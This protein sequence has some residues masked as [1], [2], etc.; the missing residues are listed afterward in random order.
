MAGRTRTN[1]AGYPCEEMMAPGTLRHRFL[2]VVAFFGLLCALSA[3]SVLADEE[4]Q[5]LGSSP[6]PQEI[7]AALEGEGPAPEVIEQTNPKAAEQLPHN[8]L[9]RGE[10]AELLSAVFAPELEATAGIFDELEVARFQGDHLA[11]L[12][13]DDQ[14]GPG[15]DP[16]GENR[17]TLL[18]STLPLRTESDSGESL[19]VDLALE[20]DEEG[21][22]QPTNPLI[23]VGIPGQLGDGISLPEAGVEVSLLGAPDERAPSI[24]EES[25]AFYPN[26]AR[27]S[28]LTVA[29]TPLGVETSTQLRSPD[30]PQGQ[31]FNLTLPADATLREVDG[32]G[33]EV[34]GQN[35]KPL[36]VVPAPT[37]IDAA[38]EAV[39]VDLET[40]GDSVLITA[41]PDQETAF[42]ILVDP[43]WQ[44]YTY[45][46][47][48]GPMPDYAGWG[49]ETNNV[50]LFQTAQ[51]DWCAACN[52]YIW[53]LELN[54]FPGSAAPWSRALWRYRVPR[55]ADDALIGK[56]PTSYINYAMFGRLG[57]DVG[58]NENNHS[59]AHDP[60][61]EYYLWDDNNGFV[62][63]GKRLGTEGNLSDP[64]WQ[65]ILQ[66]PNGNENAKQ[67]GIELVTTQPYSQWR[68][69]YV[70]DAWFELT[71]NDYPEFTES[72]SPAAW[73][74]NSPKDKISFKAVDTGLGIYEMRVREP[75]STGLVQNVGTQQ[76]CT[77]GAGN[78]CPRSWSSTA[79]GPV[80]NY[81][82][83]ILPQGENWVTLDASDAG[84][85]LASQQGTKLPEVRIKVD[86]TPPALA[87]SGNLTEQ[88]TVGTKLSNYVLKYRVTDG[89]HASAEALAPFGTQGIG[90][91]QMQRPLGSATDRA[92][93]IWMVDRE[94]NRVQEFDEEGK[95]L[96]QF[97]SKGSGNGQFLEP[98]NI[99]RTAAGKLWVTDTGNHRVQQ[100]TSSGQYIQQFGTNG[101]AGGT[102]FVSPFGIAATSDGKLWISD[103][104][105]GRVAQFRETVSQASERH[106]RNAEG[107][108]SS[109]HGNTEF[110]A[111]AGLA[112]DSQNNLWVVD[113]GN[114]RLQRF[115]SSGAYVSAFGAQ[116]AG[117]G[118]LKSPYNVAISSSG[119]L[120]VTDAGNNR[121]EEFQPSGAFVR[122]FGAQGAGPNQFTE[123][124]ALAFGAGNTIFV[125]DAGNRRIARWQ[126]AE[127][128][129][130]S[131]AAGIQIKVDGEVAKEE[132]PGC[133]TKDCELV[134]EWNL[135]SSQYSD[136]PHIVK[137]IATDGVG[138]TTTKELSIVLYPDRT[139]PSIALSGS[140]TEQ[141][142]LGTTRPRYI[143]NL[144]ASD[145]G[146]A[147][148]SNFSS[149]FGSSGSGA[150]QFAHPADA[151]IDVSGNIWIADRGNHRIQ[152]FSPSGEFLS[153]FGTWGA[154]NG[155]LKSPSSLAIDADGHIWVADKDNNRVQEF[156]PGGEYLSKFGVSGSA[157]G[158]L[159]SPEGIAIAPNGD[160]W[161]SC[162]VLT[163]KR[164]QRF[165]DKGE[166]VK[167]VGSYGSGS[168]QLSQPKGIDFDSYGN[169][170]VAD[171][172]NNRISVFNKAGEFVKQLG[173]QGSGEGQ[174]NFPVEVEVDAGDNVWIGDR[175]NNRVQLLN[176]SGEY[177]AQFGSSGSGPGQFSFNTPLGIASDGMGRI[178]V[179]D[180]NNARA[181]KW[182]T[183]PGT[184]SGVASTLVKV[185][186]SVVDSSSLGCPT[187]ACSVSREWILDA[188]S[189]AAGQHTAE[190]TTT[191]VA[192]LSTTKSLTFNIGKDTTAPQ[193][194]SNASL[195]TAPEGWV[196]QQTY[197]YTASAAD[198]GGYGNTSLMLKIDGKAVK[199][200]TQS[201]P[202]GAC[203]QAL[204]GSIDMAAYEGG[205]HPAELI[206]TDGAGN[207]STKKWNINVDPEGHISTEEATATLEAVQETS[208]VNAVGESEEEEGYEGTAPQLGLEEVNEGLEA[209]GTQV[210]T[211]ITTDPRNGVTMKIL[212]NAALS[213]PCGENEESEVPCDMYQEPESSSG[214]VPIT[215]AP[216]T[217]A[218]SASN[219]QLIDGVATVAT[220]TVANVDTI[221]RPLY[222]GMMNF[223]AI[224]DASAPETFTW[225]VNLAP[226]QELKLIDADHIEVV[227]TGTD[228]T[229]LSIMAAPARDAIG[230]SVPTNL[231]LSGPDEVSLTINHHAPSPAG[232]SFVYPVVAGVGW[233]GGFQTY[234]S[235][236]PPPEPLGGEEEGGGGGVEVE[237]DSRSVIAAVSTVGPPTA[238][239]S[240]VP[241][242]A[243]KPSVPRVARAYNFDECAWKHAPGSGIP[244]PPPPVNNPSFLRQISQQ[245][246]GHLN[247][248][249]T[250]CVG[251][252]S[253]SYAMSMSGVFHYKWGHWVWTN[254]APVC[255][256]WGPN[257]PAQVHCYIPGPNTSNDHLDVIGDFKFPPAIVTQSP[258]SMCYRLDGI[259]PLRPPP[260]YEPVFHGRLHNP[261]VPVEPG[262]SCP[263][264]N[265]INPLGR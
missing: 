225:R 257:Q 110:N 247:C 21:G 65:Y 142:S 184:S 57:Y 204:S 156:S 40:A 115:N 7:E 189:T 35:G 157:D 265:F 183:S 67:A 147:P 9:D 49:P 234:I 152:K 241:L 36:I 252:V 121:I 250:A 148:A 124:R 59:I 254:E 194:T 11:L 39:P 168:G 210:P 56:Q 128:D 78:P 214:L 172:A 233:E 60:I 144:K 176:S 188:S 245:C 43:L 95:Y 55:W 70:G 170:W 198:P 87:L 190:V 253:I 243:S 105:T 195:Y 201:C 98:S 218:Q 193:I 153:Q 93:H 216:V 182:A 256:K 19:V 120:L 139:S 178:W 16:S 135:K 239:T 133:A 134:K 162:G 97:G 159:N 181:Q 211:A 196:E 6:S 215:V 23:E 34:V 174:F 132:A 99:V 30:A 20:Q 244:D 68:H 137:V 242:A 104:G 145:P 232:G 222:D 249:P 71:D 226:E 88:G 48:G 3:S 199:S 116:G 179:T 185:D 15:I 13:P 52:N 217:T 86:H 114:H 251:T 24:V 173:S 260:G 108:P 163:N 8:D 205:A 18:E 202:D 89:T 146:S 177:L 129:P 44:I 231:S 117:P 167:R 31:T 221:I 47:L 76:G 12:A 54:S 25:T 165:N 263:W 14:F 166:F 206:A 138:L 200:A 32:G 58:W 92:G 79:G 10:A 220:N 208:S 224:R 155:Q 73:V 240:S 180:P 143:L 235:E 130:Q 169:A 74:N 259:L 27:D 46:Q 219:S 164:L 186:G 236:L 258:A 83:S 197:P 51:S 262:T 109:P 131:G 191:D 175:N 118:Q 37:A 1:D 77:G 140:M 158:Q 29:P 223:E 5:S 61:F 227:Y 107:S 102:Q 4:V 238:D 261:H 45:G 228:H 53:G 103:T 154:A 94:G 82:P 41:T 22:L 38:G 26:I 237:I 150:G 33:A 42:P 81:D 187:G 100:F 151:A 91:G 127:L 161:V 230:S 229:A 63:I 125:G 149:S 255:R 141:A 50:N 192:G 2:L 264:D 111:P 113:S 101:S 212:E 112:V 203:E 69:A 72:N 90:N 123:P 85:R 64:T 62:A 75:T 171:S 248:P 213:T 136:G 207:A 28:D 209:T 96:G 160:V 106:V 66:N 84:G 122:Q 119:N 126:N 246:H 80:L 17:S